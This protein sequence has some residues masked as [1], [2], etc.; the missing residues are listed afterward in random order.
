MIQYFDTQ[1]LPAVE[2]LNR[3]LNTDEFGSYHVPVE[4]E[5]E[6]WLIVV[7]NKRCRLDGHIISPKEPECDLRGE[8]LELD[9]A[10]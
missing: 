9:C 3:L 10:D 6:T 4:D 8:W 7:R 5:S 2:C 1:I